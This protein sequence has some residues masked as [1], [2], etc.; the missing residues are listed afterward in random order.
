MIKI[1]SNAQKSTNKEEVVRKKQQGLVIISSK[2]GR[3]TVQNEEQKDMQM[4]QSRVI[5]DWSLGS[6]AF[7]NRSF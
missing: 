3:M 5:R 7:R 6:V 2:Y 4:E 1:C